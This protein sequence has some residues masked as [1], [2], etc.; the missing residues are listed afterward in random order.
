MKKECIEHSQNWLIN[1]PVLITSPV[2]KLKFWQS[3]T[4][5]ARHRLMVPNCRS[6]H[7]A[8]SEASKIIYDQIRAQR[9]NSIFA[10]IILCRRTWIYSISRNKE[11]YL[12][13]FA[14]MK[15]K[16]K[17]YTVTYSHP[18]SA[19]FKLIYFKYRLL[20][21]LLETWHYLR[22]KLQS[23]LDIAVWP[24]LNATQPRT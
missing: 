15:C 11:D 13:E 7:T 18:K 22:A 16:H 20:A 2:I 21:K 14:E 1:N 17:I 23:K 12:S 19:K 4:F 9:S 24:M 5:K 8:I 10:G 3:G 6:S